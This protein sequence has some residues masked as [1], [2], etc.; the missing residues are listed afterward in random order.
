MDGQ[1]VEPI[2]IMSKYIVIFHQESPSPENIGGALNIGGPDVLARLGKGVFLLKI[3][4]APAQITKKLK[5]LGRSDI[6]IFGLEDAGWYTTLKDE[7]IVRFMA[8]S[9]D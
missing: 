2:P 4:E 3:E 6:S 5:T 7:D 8:S 1:K 9:P